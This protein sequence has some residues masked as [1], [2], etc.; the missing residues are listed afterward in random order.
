IPNEL[1]E[2]QERGETIF[3][4]GAG[5]SMASGLPSFRELVEKIYAELGEDW[6]LHAA[7]HEGMRED[8]VLSGQYDR[9]LRC[10]ERRLSGTNPIHNRR[11]RERI[12]SAVRAALDVS[13]AGSLENH[14]A[15]M[16]L[17]R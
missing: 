14:L 16:E 11:M 9:V 2:A 1:V 8:G 15:L 17:S 7:E 10:L 5:V 3:V 12:R 13:I 4:C 6:S